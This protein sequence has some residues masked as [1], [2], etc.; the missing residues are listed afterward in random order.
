MPESWRAPWRV[1]GAVA[2]VVPFPLSATVADVIE[3]LRGLPGGHVL[4]K[5]PGGPTTTGQVLWTRDAYGSRFGVAAAFSTR[6]ELDR[7]YLWDIDACGYQPFTVHSAYYPTPEQALAAWQA[8][9]GGL[10]AGEAAFTPVDDPWLLADLMPAEEGSLGSGGE[11]AN[12]INHIVEYHRS[13]RLAEVVIRAVGPSRPG[14]RAD[15]DAAAAATQFTAWLRA[16][17]AGQ[18]PQ[19]DLEEVS[20]E[21]ADRE[22]ASLEELVA[23][24]AD[25]WHVDGPAALYSTCS[26]H[27]IALT[28]LHVRNYY[29]DEF[30]AQLVAL[31][32]DW[33]DWLAV[34][35][36]TSAELAER[37]RPYALGKIHADVGSDDSM[38]NYR[39]RVLE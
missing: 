18:P 4:P 28:V 13:R 2:G 24:L 11:N 31:L 15:F 26:P 33:A 25:S 20:P 6:N 34:R 19:A 3:D 23:E 38:P 17:R 22:E 27:R 21:E 39:A 5:A 32:P 10:A 9:V 16:H 35:N 1:L 30:V 36:G 7:W 12:H 8:G 14:R 37:C 29:K